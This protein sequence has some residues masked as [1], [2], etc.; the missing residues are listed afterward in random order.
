M[1]VTPKIS[2]L[3]IRDEKELGVNLRTFVANLRKCI[4]S[5]ITSLNGGILNA[6]SLITISN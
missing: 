1:P 2:L 6:N 3:C 5:E 4:I